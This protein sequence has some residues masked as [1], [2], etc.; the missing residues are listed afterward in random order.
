M[1]VVTVGMEDCSNQSVVA[2]TDIAQIFILK[3]GAFQGVVVSVLFAGSLEESIGICGERIG[4]KAF[5]LR[6]V[7]GVEDDGD[8]HFLKNLLSCE[9][10]VEE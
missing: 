10:V 2:C 3:E 7:V 9:E 6:G 8:R 1:L 4:V 5:S